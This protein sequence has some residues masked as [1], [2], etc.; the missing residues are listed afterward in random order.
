MSVIFE[1]EFLTSTIYCDGAFNK[2]TKGEG[3]GS[4]VNIRGEDLLCYY[5]EFYEDM[6]YKNEILPIGRRV[7]LVSKFSDVSIQ[8]NNGAEL[9]ALLVAL[10][11]AV[12]REGVT[13]IK[14]D[15]QLLTDYWS[16]YLKDDKIAKMDP[17]KVKSIDELIKYRKLFEDK[18]GKIEKIRGGDN[19]A[20]LGW[21]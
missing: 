9:I 11:I 14:C 16:K 2:N 1:T 10:R 7:V 5:P 19:L 18:D 15:S 13:L 21:H 17:R 12:N 20:D 4:V 6:K 8:Q 3:W